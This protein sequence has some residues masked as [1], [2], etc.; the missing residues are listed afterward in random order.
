[1]DS[2]NGMALLFQLASRHQF[3]DFDA[4]FSRLEAALSP[5]IFWEAYLMRAQIKLFASDP[6]MM[7]DLAIA[8]R[9]RQ[10]PTFA[11]LNA[12]WEADAP[13][14][15]IV[16]SSEQGMVQRFSDLLPA[17]RTLMAGWYGGQGDIMVRLVQSSLCYFTGRIREALA[18]AEAPCNPECASHTDVFLMRCT[19]F[20][21]YLA[22]AESEKAE[23]CMF[24]TIRLSK[25]YPEC[26]A[27]YLAFRGWANTTTSWNGDSPRFYH[28][29]SGMKRPVLEDRLE[30]IRDGSA[31]TT[32]LEAPFMGYANRHYEGAYALRQFY[33]DLFNAIYWLS[34]GDIAQTNL[35]CRRLCKIA[36][37]T[38]LIMPVA[39]CGEQ[40]ASLL[41]YIR[42]GG[43]E[44]SAEWLDRAA[45]MATRY[46]ETLEAYRAIHA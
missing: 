1:M 23:Q 13:N 28:D 27:P 14:R 21:C 6:S 2:S 33:M 4:L 32:S 30:Y 17:A 44:I 11:C 35:N 41:R 29:E 22:L 7:D 3:E 25:S 15:F 43:F 18:F 20:R 24:D 40:V 16:F 34:A 37:A 8:Q 36:S 9:A 39:E 10:A 38:G 45:D 19:Q 31:R 5:D 42:D 26:V 12:V 46:E